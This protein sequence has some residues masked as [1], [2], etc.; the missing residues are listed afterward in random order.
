MQWPNGNKVGVT[1]TFDVDG[2]LIWKSK[3]RHGN[4]WMNS[5]LS[6]ILPFGKANSTV[7]M[8]LMRAVSTP[9]VCTP[10]LLDEHPD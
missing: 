10:N 6:T 3:V 9:F 1:F 8:N 7:C 5:T 2:P 4:Y